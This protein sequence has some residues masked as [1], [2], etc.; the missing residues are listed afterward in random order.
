[1]DSERGASI[2]RLQEWYESM[3]F[4]DWHH[5]Y[6]IEIGNIDNPGWFLRVDLKGTYLYQS[7]FEGLDL[8]RDDANDWVFCKVS[9]GV[10]Q[11]HAGPKNLDELILV[12]VNWAESMKR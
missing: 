10:F 6:G 3:T 7:R 1:M 2:H 9:E 8:Q 11:G 4:G 5:T 12:F